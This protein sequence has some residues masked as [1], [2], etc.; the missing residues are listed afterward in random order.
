MMTENSSPDDLQHFMVTWGIGTEFGGMTTMCLHRANAFRELAG[1]TAPILTFD[2]V[3]TYDETRDRLQRSGLLHPDTPLLNLYEY[4]RFLSFDEKPLASPQELAYALPDDVVVRDTNDSHGQ[5]FSSIVTNPDG[6]ATYCRRYFRADGSVFAQDETPPA[7]GS[8]RLISIYNGQGQVVRQHSSAASWYRAWLDTLVAA[9]PT[10]LIV[11]SAYVSRIVAKYQSPYVVKAVV[12]HSNHIA[13]A[14]D[15]YRGRLTKARTHIAENPHEWDGVIFLTEQQ[16]QDFIRRYGD[17]SNLF[18][19][20]NPRPRIDRLPDPRTRR[21]NR[22]VM[23]CRLEAVKNVRA[24][25]EIVDVVRKSIPDILLDVYGD[26]TQRGD[27]QELIDQRELTDNVV[28]KGYSGAAAEELETSI[29]SLLTSKYEGQPLSVMESQGRGCPPIAF[30]I[31]YGPQDLIQDGYNGFLVEAGDIDAAA[32]RIVE[33]CHDP[34]LVEETSN[35]AWE[36][37][38]RFNDDTILS[39]WNRTIELMWDQKDIAGPPF[40]FT[41]DRI[42]IEGDTGISLQGTIAWDPHMRIRCDQFPCAKLQAVPRSEG[43]IMNKP[44]H[45]VHQD[46]GRI[47]VR[48]DFD[49]GDLDRI[50]TSND[51]QIDLSVIVTFGKRRIL[52]RVPFGDATNTARV[53]PTTQMNLSVKA[54]Q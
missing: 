47:T 32:A 16:R 50:A 8:K 13:A 21:R 4:Y 40:Y 12:Y 6:S 31:R 33:L 20:S 39:H 42:D 41:C 37:S 5:L 14:G 54:S 17:T 52:I 45:V 35:H 43:E 36:S 48:G 46:T 26:G 34:E 7:G 27:L 51:Q 19:I 2:N 30:D 38:K 24:A 23:L 44:M 3:G 28:L 1:I 10:A 49:Q 22:G 18:A 25:I 29:F 11:D 53:Y 9:R 15:P